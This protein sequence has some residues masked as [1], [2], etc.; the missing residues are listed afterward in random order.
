M[1]S[2]HDR[3]EASDGE[4]RQSEATIKVALRE[5]EERYRLLVE[6]L[7]DALIIVVDDTIQYSNRAWAELVREASEAEIINGN[8]D[9]LTVLFSDDRGYS[10][11]V[12]QKDPTASGRFLPVTNDNFQR[13]ISIILENSKRGAATQIM[14]LKRDG[15]IRYFETRGVPV[16]WNGVQAIQFTVLDVTSFKAVEKRLHEYGERLKSLSRQLILTQETE[17]RAIAME[18]HDEAGQVAMSFKLQLNAILRSS[19][20][21]EQKIEIRE[22]AAVLDHYTQKLRE[23]SLDLRPSMLDDLGVIPALEWYIDKLNSKSEV[24]VQFLHSEIQSDVPPEVKIACFRIAQ[25]ALTNVLRHAEASDAVVELH[26]RDDRL[27]LNIR[28]NGKGFDVDAMQAAA[29]HGSGLGLL[30]M[31]ERT[32]LAFGSFDIRSAPGSGTEIDVEFPLHS[33]AIGGNGQ[34]G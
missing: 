2:P 3:R 23:L 8:I 29:I 20:S 26:Q 24:E 9:D 31:Q 16:K 25:E 33:K 5:S 6:S 22:M 7:P 15:E 18:L 11:V 19:T 27:V 1:S 13:T 34:D 21:E 14:G 17:R 30:G 12:E 28:D 32:V 4:F 10:A